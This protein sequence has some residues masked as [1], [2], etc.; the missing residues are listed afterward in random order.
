MQTKNRNNQ[1]KKKNLKLKKIIISLSISIFFLLLTIA[2]I[3]VAWSQ[4]KIK[5]FYY[6]TD[7]SGMGKVVLDFSNNLKEVLDLKVD[8]YLFQLTLK[9]AIIWPKLEKNLPLENVNNGNTDNLTLMAYQYEK[10]VVRARVILPFK[11][12]DYQNEIKVLT[13]DNKIEVLFP[14]NDYVVKNHP[15]NTDHSIVKNEVRAEGRPELKNEKVINNKFNEEYLRK[16]LKEDQ[17]DLTD[18]NDNDKNDRNDKNDSINIKLSANE[19]KASTSSISGAIATSATAATTTLSTS[20]SGNAENAENTNIKKENNTTKI[21][22]ISNSHT[23]NIDNNKFDFSNQNLYII[24][25]IFF[26]FL[27][28]GLFYVLVYFFKKTVLGKGKLGFLNDTPVVTVLS[29][30]YIAPKRSL[31]TVKVHNQI[32]LLSN[33]EQGIHFL[34]EIKD[35]TGLIKQGERY[36]TGSNFDSSIDNAENDSELNDKVKLKNLNLSAI[37]TDADHSMTNKEKRQQQIE[38]DMIV[39]NI[40]NSKGNKERISFSEQLKKKIKGLRPLQ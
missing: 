38:E 34:A 32:F 10:D 31:I 33:S 7:S 4:T 14:L 23:T 12:Q 40:I 30:N 25:F 11:I 39:Q 6:T 27:V 5:D 19:K 22:A 9:N 26:M 1:R 35:T 16:L 2:S 13:Y 8:N 28:L 20:T 17:D 18:K 29:N 36:V 24:K 3:S 37:T 21:K 15:K